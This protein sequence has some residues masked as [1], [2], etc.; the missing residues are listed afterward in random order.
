MEKKIIIETIGPDGET[1]REEKVIHGEDIHVHHTHRRDHDHHEHRRPR[2][3][4]PPRPP[5]PNGDHRPPKPHRDHRPPRPH[6]HK[7]MVTK[8]FDDKKEMIAYVNEKGEENSHIDI[9]KIDEELYKV[10][11]VQKKEFKE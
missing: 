7:N 2:D 5:K 9:F 1:I 4:R 10:V 11:V 6:M 8:L 3:H